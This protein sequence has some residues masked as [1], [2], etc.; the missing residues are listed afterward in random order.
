MGSGNHN[1]P[2]L[3]HI[4][5]EH[6]FSVHNR[7]AEIYLRVHCTENRI[8]RAVASGLPLRQTYCRAPFEIPREGKPS[9]PP[10]GGRLA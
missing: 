6:E 1:I 10:S 5:K 2:D 4:R 3:W 8:K 9:R 7:S